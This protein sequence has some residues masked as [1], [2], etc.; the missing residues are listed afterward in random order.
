[1]M[2]KTTYS[3]FGEMK[4][5]GTGRYR[6]MVIDR[7]GN[8]AFRRVDALGSAFANPLGDGVVIF[9]YDGWIKIRGKR[10]Y[11]AKERVVGPGM[12]IHTEIP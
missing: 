6:L 2:A 1:M 7:K 12:M 9:D 8:Y 3:A 5:L 10:M 4:F 11:I